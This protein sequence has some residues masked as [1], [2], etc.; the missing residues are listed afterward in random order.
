MRS[1]FR[2]SLFLYVPR[3]S[4]EPSGYDGFRVTVY[5]FGKRVSSRRL[6][7]ILGRYLVEEEDKELPR[8][9][10]YEGRQVAASDSVGLGFG[11]CEISKIEY[12]RGRLSMPE[13]RLEV[14]N[15]YAYEEVNARLGYSEF[16]GKAAQYG[17]DKRVRSL[18][19]RAVE[20]FW[21]WLAS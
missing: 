16:L 4:D 3:S 13:R 1:Y 9:Y 15:L 5:T 20:S 21:K 18:M 19:G 14:F 17:K 6:R 8:K 7:K 10:A 11:W 2:S 12:T